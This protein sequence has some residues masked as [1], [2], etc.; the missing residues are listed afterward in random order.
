MSYTSMP[1]NILVIEDNT[2]IANLVMVNLRGKHLQVD[3]AADGKTGL[4]KALT[5][6]YQLIIL[7]LMLPGMDGMD[8]PGR[9]F[10]TR[11]DVDSKDVRARPRAGS[12]SWCR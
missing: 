2:D 1:K 11:A 7:D 4:D 5:G 3:H 10:H 9:E 12:G 8:A 6:N